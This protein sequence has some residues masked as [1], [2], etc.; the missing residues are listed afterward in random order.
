M[1]RTL[2]ISGFRSLRDVRLELGGLNIVT[3]ANGSG[4]SSLYRALRLIADIAQGQV[5]ASLAEQ[6]GFRSAR[7]AGP[8]S[9]AR[10]V[11]S[12]RY[13]VEGTVR[14]NP[15]SLK[16]GFADDAH[17]YALDL[18]LPIPGPATEF[19]HDPQI[20]AEALWFGP[21]L[22]AR[23]ALAL[24]TGPSVRLRSENGEWRQALTGIAPFD[25]MMT[26]CAAPGDGLELLGGTG[27]GDRSADQGSRRAGQISRPGAVCERPRGH[28]P[29]SDR[30][31]RASGS[32]SVPGK[33]S[34]DR[35]AP[36]LA[37]NPLKSL[38]TRKNILG[39]AC[40]SLQN[41]WTLQGFPYPP[42]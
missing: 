31:G 3:G 32:S 2:A 4:K 34:R 16:L 37:G 6:G 24:R 22:G 21:T 28:P 5:I 11:K 1:I 15:V 33:R 10:S 29:A 41:P 40:K 9:F 17:G 7:W 8:E 36:D 19:G 30:K 18:G 25:S 35:G 13:P 26:H 12:G 23:G 42:R 14:R 38:K 27:R 20:K 39:G